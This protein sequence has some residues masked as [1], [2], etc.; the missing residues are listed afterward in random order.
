MLLDRA[1]CAGS[2]RERAVPT[3]PQSGAQWF[4][5]KLKGLGHLTFRVQAVRC[6]LGGGGPA[7]I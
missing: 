6:R 1:G 4:L 5:G 2:S 3:G 7:N